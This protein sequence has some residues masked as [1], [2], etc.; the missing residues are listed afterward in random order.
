MDFNHPPGFDEGT[1]SLYEQPEVY[2]KRWFLLGILSSSLLLVIM[3][4]SGLNVALATL[5]QDLGASGSELQWIVNVYAIA[6]GGLLLTAG[7][8]G[9]RFG[10]KGALLSGLTIFGLGALLGGMATSSTMLMVW[11]ATMGLG[12]AFVMPAT[13]SLITEV[14]A[15]A[16]R[17][18]AI[19][20]WAGFAGGGASI[21][22][23]LTGLFVSGWWIVPAWGWEAGLLYNVP[24]VAAVM[25]AAGLWLPRSQRVGKVPLDPLGAVLSIVALVSLLYAIIEGPERGWTSREVIVGLL[26]AVAVGL[27]FVQWQRR[28]RAPMLPLELFSSRSFRTGVVV[29]GLAFV[30]MIGFWFLFALYIQFALGYTALQAGLATLPEALAS[31]LF[32]PPTAY[33]A[34]RFGSRRVMAAGFLC[35]ATAF[36]WLSQVGTDTSYWFFVG[37]LVL[38]GVGLNLAT[39]PGISDIMASTPDEKAGVGSAV[40]DTSHE[41]GSALG[42]ATFGSLS[43]SLYRRRVDIDSLPSGLQESA[44][45]SIGAALGTA[46][47]LTES[48]ELA[49]GELSSAVAE[50]GS[51]F[52]DAFALT[53]GASG[54]LSLVAAIFLFA[55]ARA[56]S[57]MAVQTSLDDQ[58]M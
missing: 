7:A 9:D 28:A 25:I 14:F 53:M 30:V 5:Q 56:R 6:F 16:E 47:E 4:V 23:L 45:E 50:L 38:A 41:F 39:I 2:S 15:P 46:H 22:P 42:I 40:N 35:I 13:L 43:A 29:V 11:R 1:V 10:R 8:L 44:R 54:V 58:S 36:G 26:L 17:A 37:P 55:G 33:L 21:G 19:A 12:A 18:K 3:S 52:T 24:V 20:I 27:A 48:G 32:A 31:M 57:T 34:A 49:A 51:A